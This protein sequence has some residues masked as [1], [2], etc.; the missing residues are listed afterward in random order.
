M[1]ETVRQVDYFYTEVPNKVGEGAKA[2]QAL[3]DAG[4]N[5]TAFSGFPSG[6][7]AQLDFFPADSAAFKAVA[8]ANRWKLVGPKRGFMVQGDDRIGAIADLVGRLAAA[9]ISVTAIDAVGVGER[10]GAICWVAPRDVKKAAKLL[11][12]V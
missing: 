7:R 8:K 3:K 11:E 6:R 9:N 4:V 2:L 12:A 5:L 1:A 10:Y